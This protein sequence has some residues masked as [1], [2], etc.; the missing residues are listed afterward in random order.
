MI[1]SDSFSSTRSL[2]TGMICSSP[3]RNSEYASTIPDAANISEVR[4]GLA[5]VPPGWMITH[6]WAAVGRTAAIGRLMSCF[7]C[8]GV[9]VRQARAVRARA[10]V[11][12]TPV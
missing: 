2:A 7:R 5:A 11:R 8:T 12:R 1:A 4:S 3:C 6:T 9:A 10:T